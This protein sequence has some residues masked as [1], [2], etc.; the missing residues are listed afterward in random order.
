VTQIMRKK[1]KQRRLR[2]QP[3]STMR[4]RLIQKKSP[5][6]RRMIKEKQLL[7]HKKMVALRRPTKLITTRFSRRDRP[8]LVGFLSQLRR[9]SL[10]PRE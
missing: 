8:S 5:K 10:T 2:S 6:R 3:N 9:L 4:I 7:K 1:K